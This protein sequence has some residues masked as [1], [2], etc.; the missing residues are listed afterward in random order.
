MSD[1]VTARDLDLHPTHHAGYPIL[2]CPLCGRFGYGWRT[3]DGWVLVEL[4]HAR[5]CPV[6]LRPGRCRCGACV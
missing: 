4:D 6:R 5:A 2:S 3:W 1:T